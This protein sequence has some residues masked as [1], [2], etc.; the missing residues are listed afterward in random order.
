MGGCG[1][2][3]KSINALVNIVTILCGLAVIAIA[4]FG[5]VQMYDSD[6]PELSSAMYWA[7]WTSLFVGF[8]IVGL[9]TCAMKATLKARKCGMAFFAILQLVFGLVVLVTGVA[10][11][12]AF[13]AQ[14]SMS[15]TGGSQALTS[16]LEKSMNDMNLGLYAACCN[17]NL[18]TFSQCPVGVQCFWESDDFLSARDTE[19]CAAIT[20][21]DKLGW[22]APDG[23]TSVEE[24]KVNVTESLEKSL[25]PV[26]VAFTVFGTLLLLA[27]M[28]NVFLVC[29]GCKSKSADENN[30]ANGMV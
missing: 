29:C 4:I 2:C 1:A 13:K 7:P 8:L 25:Y 24:F 11:I 14:E 23:S 6:T 9:A 16:D 27:A 28:G 10:S 5:L 17:S 26:G 30:K 12:E 3:F 18:M 19:S 15:A 21:S 20:D 22:C